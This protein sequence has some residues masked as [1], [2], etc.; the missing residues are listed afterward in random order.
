ML[1]LM[2]AQCVQ[3]AS[4]VL[5]TSYRR[6]LWLRLCCVQDQHPLLAANVIPTN[7]KAGQATAKID[8][9]KPHASLQPVQRDEGAEYV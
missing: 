2:P 9:Q 1:V 6:S 8:I 5:A 4:H 7:Y 3:L